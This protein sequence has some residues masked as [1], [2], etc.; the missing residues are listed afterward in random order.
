MQTLSVRK[1][2][3]NVSTRYMNSCMVN[4]WGKNLPIIQRVSFLHSHANLSKSLCFKT[5][6][7]VFDQ[8]S[9]RCSY[10]L[11][12][13]PSSGCTSV[14]TQ[15]H[16]KQQKCSVSS[17]FVKAVMEQV[18]K[19]MSKNESLKKA[20]EDIEKAGTNKKA[21]DLRNNFKGTWQAIFDR[22]K[23]LNETLA[24]QATHLFTQMRET[25]GKMRRYIGD[26]VQGLDLYI[27]NCPPLRTI[28]NQI[29]NFF[30]LVL[31]GFR[32]ILSKAKHL[33]GSLKDDNKTQAELKAE[34]WRKWQSEQT[35][36]TT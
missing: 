13:S 22:I 25:N 32:M 10:P 27:E 36:T 20:F 18:K 35:N 23:G 30:S 3:L 2:G 15:D 12:R 9:K 29:N 8:W 11:L 16:N 17:S 21:E 28:K 4:H 33:V 34:Q 7:N 19:D 24:K 6:H 14:R 5:T 26:V 31:S 1:T